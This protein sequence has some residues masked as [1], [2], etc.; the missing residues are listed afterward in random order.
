MHVYLLAYRSTHLSRY[1]LAM[2]WPALFR[3]DKKSTLG[4]STSGQD[5]G[6]TAVE[7][8]LVAEAAVDGAS[9]LLAIGG[10]R[11]ARHFL[12]YM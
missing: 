4:G 11:V 8:V 7:L 5:Q 2:P 3:Q 10:D 1:A 6:S 9:G 12:T